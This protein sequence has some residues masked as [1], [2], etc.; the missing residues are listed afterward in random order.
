MNPMAT[1]AD[2]DVSGASQTVD[3]PILSCRKPKVHVEYDE[4]GSADFTVGKKK[5]PVT[6]IL[7][8]RRRRA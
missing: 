6:Y 5:A 8:D 4:Q 3:M 7:V 1:R 2:V